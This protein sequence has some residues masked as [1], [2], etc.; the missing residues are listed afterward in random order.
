MTETPEF[1]RPVAVSSVFRQGALDLALEASPEERKA[2][3]GRLGLVDLATLAAALSLEPWQQDGIAVRG[4]F[5]AELAQSCVVTLEP[6]PCRLTGP[7][8]ARYLP[9]AT[10]AALSPGEL[11]SDPEG[12]EPPEPLPASGVIDLGELVVQHLAVALDPYPRK[13][14]VA[15]DPAGAGLDQTAESPFAKL[16]ALKS[17]PKG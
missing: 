3:A 9:A 6:V 11:L 8:E 15:F 2:L 5:T 17:P 14:G 12:P 7:V 13:P 16:A 10:A 1:S 4:T